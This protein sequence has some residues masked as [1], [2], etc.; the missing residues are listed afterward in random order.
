MVKYIEDIQISCYTA[1]ISASEVEIFITKVLRQSRAVTL[2]L[3][4]E[5]KRLTIPM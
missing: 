4:C 5:T 2:L 1:F 3:I